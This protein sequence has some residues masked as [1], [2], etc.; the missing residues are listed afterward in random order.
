[1]RK[2]PYCAEMVKAEAK[3]CR[4][5]QRDLPNPYTPKAPDPEFPISAIPTEC[6][7]CHHGRMV[8]LTKGKRYLCPQCSTTYEVT[9]VSG[10]E[11]GDGKSTKVFE[12]TERP[13]VCNICGCRHLCLIGESR[14][15]CDKCGTAYQFA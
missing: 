12:V 13:K 4:Y 9:A 10:S 14:V 6:P 5:C 8:E 3:I 7:D 1:M 15:R 2:C 11:E